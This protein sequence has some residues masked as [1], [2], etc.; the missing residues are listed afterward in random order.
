MYGVLSND[1]QDITHWLFW[2]ICFEAGVHVKVIC[3]QNV[4]ASG[5]AT[6]IPGGGGVLCYNHKS[7][8]VHVSPAT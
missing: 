5:V 8:A 7:S 4:S 1:V 3:L 2:S 6:D